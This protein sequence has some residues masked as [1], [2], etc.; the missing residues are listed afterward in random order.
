MEQMP[1]KI[2]HYHIDRNLGKGGMGEVFL[3]FDPI[4]KRR[5]ALKQIRKE[6]SQNSSIQKRFLREALIAAQLSHPSI[7]PIY[8]I[9]RETKDVFYTMPYVEGETLRQV[10]KT[11]QDEDKEGEIKHPIG[12]SIPSLASIFLKGVSSYCLC[13]L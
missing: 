10:L 2:G 9:H 1:E 11:A 12:C 4:C 8:S 7:I 13:A 5:I 6:L 3:A